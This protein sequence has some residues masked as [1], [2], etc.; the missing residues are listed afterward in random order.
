MQVLVTQSC[1]TLY[2][3]MDCSPPGSSVH[4]IS[5]ASTGVGCHFL[6]QGIFLIQ[7]LN[8][9]SCIAG[10]FFTVWD[11]REAPSN[12]RASGKKISR[13]SLPWGLFSLG[14]LGWGTEV[15]RGFWTVNLG[16]PDFKF[17]TLN[18]WETPRNSKEV[19]RITEEDWF[20]SE[21]LISCDFKHYF[22]PQDKESDTLQPSEQ[23][24]SSPYFIFFLFLLP[25]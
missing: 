10:R 4:S 23:Q 7:G 25:E 19:Y 8:W 6:L 17:T 15:E 24:Q 2:T 21:I 20:G 11:T 3:P 13:Q 9:V 12:S 5:Q 1:P 22:S 18:K 14:L 16:N